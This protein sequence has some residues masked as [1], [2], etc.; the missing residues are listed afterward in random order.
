MHNGE[1][2]EWHKEEHFP[3]ETEEYHGLCFSK[4]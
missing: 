3:A 1:H 4:I 2:S